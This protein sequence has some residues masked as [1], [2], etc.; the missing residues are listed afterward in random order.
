VKHAS[1]SA[2]GPSAE[3]RQ[4][5]K[6]LQDVAAHRYI[7]VRASR[8]ENLL[9]AAPAALAYSVDSNR[10]G[11]VLAFADELVFYRRAA[12]GGGISASIR[13]SL[14][15]GGSSG[16]GLVKLMYKDIAGSSVE[17]S[18][19]AVHLQTG[20]REYQSDNSGSGHGGG[21][22]TRTPVL[23]PMSQPNHKRP[24]TESRGRSSISSLSRSSADRVKRAASSLF[25][26]GLGGSIRLR[27][28]TADGVFGPSLS[29]E[30]PYSRTMTLELESPQICVEMQAHLQ[31]H[32]AIR[33]AQLAMCPF[34]C[35]H[36]LS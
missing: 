25:G 32:F 33:R 36:D 31:S 27:R 5:I 14:G 29:Q 20:T 17:G 19:L 7:V 1:D 26:M 10:H 8:Y 15:A 24:S 3:V 9:Y 22:P 6:E 18:K 34:A 28:G 16:G 4:I 11:H 21:S 30:F 12:G 2:S 35:V 23:S 13:A